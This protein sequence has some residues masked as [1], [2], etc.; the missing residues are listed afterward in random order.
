MHVAEAVAVAVAVAVGGAEGKELGEAVPCLA[1][2]EEARRLPD[3]ELQAVREGV[4]AVLELGEG[5]PVLGC[6]KAGL[7]LGVALV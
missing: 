2:V 5:E 6:V 3:R 7:A 1:V 4:G